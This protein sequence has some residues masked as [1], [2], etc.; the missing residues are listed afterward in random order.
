MYH[1]LTGRKHKAVNLGSYNYLGFSEN[2]GPRT[3]DVVRTTQKYGVGIC[4]SRQ[5]LGEYLFTI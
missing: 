5:E 3:G 1:R 2:H 4:S